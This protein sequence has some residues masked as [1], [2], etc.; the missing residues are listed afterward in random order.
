MGIAGKAGDLAFM[1][2]TAGLG[3]ATIYLSATFSVNVYRGL[4]WHNAQP[5]KNENVDL[6]VNHKDPSTS[7]VAR[8]SYAAALKTGHAS[9]VRSE[10]NSESGLQIMP[11]NQLVAMHNSLKEMETQLIKL[12]AAITFL[13]TKI[14]MLS[15]G[16]NR[17]VR[18]KTKIGPNPLD[19][20]KGKRKIGFSLLPITRSKRVWLVKRKSGL[21]KVGSTSGINVETSVMECH[22]PQVTH[23][24]L[25]VD[26]KPL[27]PKEIMAPSSELK[28]NGVLP[29]SEGDV[30]P[31]EVVHKGSLEVKGLDVI[32]LERTNGVAKEV[33]DLNMGLAS[34]SCVKECLESGVQLDTGSGDN[35]ASLVSLPPIADWILPKVNEIQQFV[36]ISHGGCEDQFKELITAIEASHALET[37]SSFKK[38]RE[39]QR[40]SWAINYNAKGGSSTRGK[41]KGRAL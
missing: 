3:V 18:N 34:V 6:E 40:L 11:Q 10:G 23:D 33:W 4:A 32:P 2:F 41:F 16:G 20:D 13:S 21:F 12:K 8:R 36:G 9:G 35:V 7:T 29:K 31:V 22:S 5:K 14:D 1:A 30:R 26:I 37:K 19:L 24:R 38:S 27:V 15:A 28:E 17:V 39:L 25:I